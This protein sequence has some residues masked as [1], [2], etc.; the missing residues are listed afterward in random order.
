ML[1][2]GLA[3][4]LAQKCVN[5]QIRLV[6]LGDIESEVSGTNSLRDYVREANRGRQVCFVRTLDELKQVSS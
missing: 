4:E 3:G 1:R 5:Y 6:V 2:S